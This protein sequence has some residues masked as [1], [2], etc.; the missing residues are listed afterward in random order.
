[1]AR[2]IPF[3]LASDSR[4]DLEWMERVARA[5]ERQTIL[6]VRPRWRVCAVVRAFRSI[7]KG[8]EAMPDACPV[9]VSPDFT[10][11]AHGVHQDYQDRRPFA[12]IRDGKPKD[13]STA[14]SHEIIEVL[15]DPTGRRTVAGPSIMPGQGPVEYLVEVCDPPEDLSYE[16]EGVDV[17]DFCTPRYYDPSAPPGSRFDHL[18][19]IETPFGVLADGYLSWRDAR[20]GRWWQRRRF[21][22]DDGFTDLGPM[23]DGGDGSLRARID[24]AVRALG[25]PSGGAAGARASHGR[26]A[27][28]RWTAEC[29][30]RGAPYPPR[31]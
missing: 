29:L 11:L 4:G 6:H 23:D 22:G 30:E 28:M 14:V 20:S 31:P 8:L 18:G 12:L 19:Q 27:R 15:V 9:L 13:V 5:V 10:F 1:M 16:V 7:D 17:S 21:A 24:H 25:P 3:V 26:E 2:S